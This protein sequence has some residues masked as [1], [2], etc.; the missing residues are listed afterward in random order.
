MKM[1]LVRLGG[2]TGGWVP[3]PVAGGGD[4]VPGF[5]TLF[6]AAGNQVEAIESKR[7][8]LAGSGQ[9]P[10]DRVKRGVGAG[11][12]Q[13]DR[14]EADHDNQ[15]QHHGVFHRGR[16]IFGNEQVLGTTK[17]SVHRNP[18]KQGMNCGRSRS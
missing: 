13:R 12:D 5:F 1:P 18:L 6:G 11:A 3:R 14:A 15:G 4:Y 17:K 7:I 10:S 9:R 2:P 8:G 16:A